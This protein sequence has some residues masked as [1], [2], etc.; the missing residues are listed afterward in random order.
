MLM[1][2]RQRYPYLVAAAGLLLVVGLAL[3]GYETWQVVGRR[4]ALK[5]EEVP[6]V[7]GA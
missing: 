6:E 4:R 1:I 5:A 3:G 2:R 7:E